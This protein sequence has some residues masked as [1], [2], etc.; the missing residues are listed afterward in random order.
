MRSILEQSSAWGALPWCTG[1]PG[2]GLLMVDLGGGCR[3]TA[4][5]VDGAVMVS[6]DGP[7]SLGYTWVESPADVLRVLAEHEARRALWSGL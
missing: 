4:H 5:D 6:S 1:R 3:L 7:E 2:L